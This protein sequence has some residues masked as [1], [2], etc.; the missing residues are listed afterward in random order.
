MAVV[1][2]EPVPRGRP[3]GDPITVYAVETHAG[4]VLKTLDS[5][6]A[7]LIGPRLKAISCVSLGSETPTK[8]TPIIGGPL[9]AISQEYAID[10]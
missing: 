8:A 4:E 1:Y 3:D 5:Q 9:K 10:I 7:R 2:I 6:K